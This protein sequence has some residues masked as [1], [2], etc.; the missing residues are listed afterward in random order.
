MYGVRTMGIEFYAL[1]KRDGTFF[2]LGRGSWYVLNHDREAFSDTEYLAHKILTEVYG[3]DSDDTD[4]EWVDFVHRVQTDLAPALHAF[5]AGASAS[6]LEVIYDNTDDYLMARC[7]RYRCVGTMYGSGTEERAQMIEEMN[8]HLVDSPLNRRYY[9][10]DNYR[11][12][13]KFE[14][15]NRGRLP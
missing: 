2:E 7:L 11:G 6:D 10:P 5:A 14:D 9:N 3:R 4:D 1:N 12:H 13:P 8:K 15:F